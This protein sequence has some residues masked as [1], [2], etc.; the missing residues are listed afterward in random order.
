MSN[1]IVQPKHRTEIVAKSH[2]GFGETSIEMRRETAAVAVAERERAAVEARYKMALMRPRSPDEAR[3]RILDHCKRKTFADAARYAIP[4]GG[5]KIVGPSIR[6]VETA[7]AEWGNILVQ[8]SVVWDDTEERRVEIAVTD[9]ER[10]LCYPKE[11]V[12]RKTMEKRSLRKGQVAI[13]QR[14]N[15]SGDIVYI[16]EATE[17]DMLTKQGA[18]E[19]KAIR[20][21]GLRIL[22]ADIVEE[23]MEQVTATL[24]S[25]AVQDPL[26]AKKA[27]VDTFAS[28]G[29]YP[30]AL[31]E[32]LGH[33]L[34]Q[35]TDAER[36][37]LKV[38]FRSIRDGVATWA[39]LV[40]AAGEKQAPT[41]PKSKVAK[42]V[43]KGRKKHTP[44]PANDE[45]PPPIAEGYQDVE[46]VDELGR[47]IDTLW[48][49]LNKGVLTDDT[50][51]RIKKLPDGDDRISLVLKWDQL[52]AGAGPVAE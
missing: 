45:A 4:V 5:K 37:D 16:V 12:I 43:K 34:E 19:S 33:P 10:N 18:L 26:Q 38:M 44:K 51:S 22:P 52:K 8:C 30:E 47:E 36:D 39:D 11:V 35:T 14:P 21:T 24:R 17:G 25:G 23:A 2:A 41:E 7:L 9:L 13:G 40:E 20:T 48:H 1:D 6:F 29:V 50:L 42:L 3:R 28:V 32:Y 15:A 27:L 49:L 31:A 46:D